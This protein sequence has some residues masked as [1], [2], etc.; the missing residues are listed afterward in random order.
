MKKRRILMPA[1]FGLAVCL[2]VTAWAGGRVLPGLWRIAVKT[3]MS[4]MPDMPDMPDMSRMPPEVRAQMKARGIQF[5][6]GGTTLDLR[7]CITSEE[8]NADRFSTGNDKDCKLV[9]MHFAGNSYAADVVCT[10]EHKMRGHV[11]GTVF[12]P[13]HYAGTT[14]VTTTEGGRAATSVTKIDARR[15]GTDCGKV[16]N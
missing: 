13:E 3:Q 16:K 8:A 15:V 14:T 4:G 10:G 2:P 6:A 1:A 5:G 12:S 7:H 11:E 9:G